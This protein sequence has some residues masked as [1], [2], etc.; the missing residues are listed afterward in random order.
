MKSEALTHS[1]LVQRGCS[2][3]RSERRRSIVLAEFRT[4]AT[5]EKPDCI[6]WN[7]DGWSIVIECKVS[8]GDFLRDKRKDV[9]TRDLHM[10]DGMGQE[11]WYLSPPG[12]I[13][14]KDLPA[15]WGLLYATPKG[16]VVERHA[17]KNILHVE[18]QR[19]ELTLLLAFMRRLLGIAKLQKKWKPRDEDMAD[20][21]AMVAPRRR[22]EKT[23]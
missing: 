16:I 20:L 19:H 21:W 5:N 18:R 6:G 22:T 4:T 7:S 9:R 3:L 23:P 17:V 14:L 12:I 13:L 11:R 2:W 10:H 15:D 1:E 8:R